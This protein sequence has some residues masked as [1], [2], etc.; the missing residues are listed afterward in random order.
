[1]AAFA[2]LLNGSWV[3]STRDTNRPPAS[4]LP[5]H[6]DVK[7]LWCD[8]SFIKRMMILPCKLPRYWDVRLSYRTATSWIDQSGV[9]MYLG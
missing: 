7:K 1:M 6:M 8:F 4:T 9:G 2:V 5:N 3:K